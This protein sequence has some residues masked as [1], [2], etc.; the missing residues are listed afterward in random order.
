M[1]VGLSLLFPLWVLT[2][3]AWP[4]E[5]PAS[6]GRLRNAFAASLGVASCSASAR[7]AVRRR[8]LAPRAPGGAASRH[9]P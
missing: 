9:A 2:T 4:A 8:R 3:S 6:A 5:Y 7:A 1:I